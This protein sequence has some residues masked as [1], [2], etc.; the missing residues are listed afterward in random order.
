MNVSENA[1]ETKSQELRATAR[2]RES[3]LEFETHL[4]AASTKI[5]ITEQTSL[6]LPQL[7]T[8]DPTG[9]A[10]KPP[11][12]VLEQL[13]SLNATHRMGHLLC[14]SRHPDF[15]LDLIQRQG[16]SQSMPWLADLVESSEGS[17]RW[18][19]SLFF[20]LSFVSKK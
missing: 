15:L 17:L 7:I 4:A 2:E 8:M 6:L 9:P 16:T 18:L 3:I 11:V 14:R 13:A 1:D 12:G 20:Y 5:T 10:R 19:I